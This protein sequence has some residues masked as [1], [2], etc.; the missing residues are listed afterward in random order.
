MAA[1]WNLRTWTMMNPNRWCSLGNCQISYCI[2]DHSLQLHFPLQSCIDSLRARMSSRAVKLLAFCQQHGL[3]AMASWR[4]VLVES[5]GRHDHTV[6]STF[7]AFE[8]VKALT[9]E[10]LCCQLTTW[11]LHAWNCAVQPISNKQQKHTAY[12]SLLSILEA[13]AWRCDGL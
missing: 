1:G 9:V 7:F 5:P 2:E 13:S 12:Y 3:L 6:T 8:S 11:I 4:F 10:P